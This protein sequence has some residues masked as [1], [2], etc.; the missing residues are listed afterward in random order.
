MLIPVLKCHQFQSLKI[1]GSMDNCIK[2]SPNVVHVP[3]RVIKGLHSTCTLDYSISCQ[4]RDT[5][6]LMLLLAFVCT[7]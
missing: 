2:S 3:M 5:A 1:W 6:N 4:Y 7:D